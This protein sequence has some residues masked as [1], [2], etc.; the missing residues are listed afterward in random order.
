[1]KEDG[2]RYA[3]PPDHYR[4]HTD[5]FETST[6]I[7]GNATGTPIRYG[8]RVTRAFNFLLSSGVS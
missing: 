7:I 3:P 8:Q 5:S 1:M 2:C 4:L 6:I